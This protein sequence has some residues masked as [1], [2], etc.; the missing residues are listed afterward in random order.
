VYLS[1]KNTYSIFKDILYKLCFISHKMLF[2]AE[3]YHILFKKYSCF[4]VKLVLKIKYP[5]K[6]W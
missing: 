2:N 6:T 3:I 4:F 1:N 5:P